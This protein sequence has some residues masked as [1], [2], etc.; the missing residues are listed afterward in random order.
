M[1]KG[2]SND[3]SLL[4]CATQAKRANV[5]STVAFLLFLEVYTVLANKC[6]HVPSSGGWL[7][8]AKINVHQSFEP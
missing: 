5:C 8:G 1:A 2:Y 6:T 7:D 3:P 4:V